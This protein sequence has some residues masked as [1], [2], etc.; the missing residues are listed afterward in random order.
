ME[1]FTIIYKN[2]FFKL[3]RGTTLDSFLRSQA[4]YERYFSHSRKDDMNRKRFYNLA[5]KRNN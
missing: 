3:E 2:K 4:G 1:Y 5:N